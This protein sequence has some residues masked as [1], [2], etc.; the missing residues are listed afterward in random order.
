MKTSQQLIVGTVYT[1][2]QLQSVFNIVD[3]TLNTGVFRVPSYD[4]VWLFVTEIKTSDRKQYVD[5]LENNILSWGGQERGR[6][7]NLVIN[8]ENRGLELL[9]FYRR[10]RRQYPGAGFRFEGFL[11]YL[12]HEGNQP[13]H[14]TFYLLRTDEDVSLEDLNSVRFEE[15]FFE[16]SARKR[17]TNHFERN[18][19]LRSAAIAI[20]GTQCMGCGFDFAEYYGERG[21]GYIEVHHLNPV[22]TL[23]DHQKVDPKTDM[24]V[25]CANCHRMVHRASENILSLSELKQIIRK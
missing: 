2:N 22:S 23:A 21:L 8:H 19:K 9:L 17:F 11:H 24:I 4:S 13:A 25:L 12:S 20:H 6:T 16:G 18:R 3:A 1:R 10:D 5:K 14:F 15:E 7:N